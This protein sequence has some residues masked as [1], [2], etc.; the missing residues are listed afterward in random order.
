MMVH[1]SELFTCLGKMYKKQIVGPF[2]DA[3]SSEICMYYVINRELAHQSYGTLDKY[4]IYTTSIKYFVKLINHNKLNKSF[5]VLINIEI[6]LS[7]VI[8]SLWS[9]I[10]TIWAVTLLFT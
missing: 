5:M 6:P 9:T 8:L 1:T 3:T 10:F 4:T 7:T 2:L